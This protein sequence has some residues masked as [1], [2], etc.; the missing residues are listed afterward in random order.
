MKN[1]I[2]LLTI[3]LN[4]FCL[5]SSTK[6]KRGLDGEKSNDIII[7][8]TNDVHCGVNDKIGYDGLMLYKK[9]LQQKYNNVLLVDAGDH[10][11]GGTIGMITN[12]TAII[13]IM[14]KLGYDAATLGNLEFDYG[15]PQLEKVEKLLDCSY[16]SCNYCFRENKTSI[17]SPFKVIEKGGKKIGFIGIATPETIL[18]TYLITILDSSGKPVYDF[19]ADNNSKDL[20]DQVQKHVDELKAQGVDYIIVLAHLGKG[21]TSLEEHTSI[22]LLKNLKNV[23]ALIDGHTH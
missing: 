12:G 5:P 1:I 21:G 15:I 13:E 4:I 23:N 7:L 6:T 11:Q 2:I 17:Y 18:K 8:H 16:I 14:N 9:Q 20:Y 22:G 19:L 10:I 3:L